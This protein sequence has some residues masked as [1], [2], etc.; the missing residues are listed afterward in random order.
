MCFARSAGACCTP[1]TMHI[2]LGDLGQVKIKYMRYIIYVQAA[3][4][5][6]GGNQNLMLACGKFLEQVLTL[7]LAHITRDH[8]CLDAIPTQ[9][10]INHFCIAFGV[11]KHD[12]ALRIML[13]DKTN[14]EWNFFV[15]GRVINCLC[16]FFGI[17]SLCLYFNFDGLI[18][19]FVGKLHD[20]M[21]ECRRKQHTE[22]F[23]WL[24]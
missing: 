19:V 15:I 4:C 1:D 8:N 14:Q 24:G 2:V 9:K 16:D 5:Y 22:A 18:H 10:V 3:C 13:L 21:R 20:P 7:V 12:G 6:I 11:Y 23:F 17:N